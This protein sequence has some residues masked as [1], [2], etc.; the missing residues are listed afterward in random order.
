M[1][2]ADFRLLLYNLNSDQEDDFPTVTK[3]RTTVPA[4]AIIAPLRTLIDRTGNE[5]WGRKPNNDKD[6]MTRLTK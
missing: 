1:R 4:S 6:T 2:N 3:R 5:G